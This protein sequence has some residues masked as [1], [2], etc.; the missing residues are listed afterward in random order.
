MMHALTIRYIGIRRVITSSVGVSA[1]F[2]GSAEVKIIP[3]AGIW[4][5]GASSSVLT[6]NV[7]E[8]LNLKP[9]GQTRVNHA[10][11]SDITNTYLVNFILP[12]NVTIENVVVTEGKLPSGVDLLIGMDIINL[13][14]F[15]I[16]NLSSNTV[17]SFRIPSSICYD[18][19]SDANTHNK[20]EEFKAQRKPNN[21]ATKKKRKKR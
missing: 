1:P 9:T 10:G 3:F 2:L 17:M 19:V 20:L 16:T 18:Y 6:K 21:T 7:V 8:R 5:T 4:D 13:G 14:D 15:S 12:M 11:G